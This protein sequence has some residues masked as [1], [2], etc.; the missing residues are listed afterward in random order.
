MLRRT[1]WEQGYGHY[2][3][4]RVMLYTQKLEDVLPRL[5]A[6]IPRRRK[7]IF[8]LD[9]FGYSQVPFR[10]LDSIFDT[11][12]KPEVILTFAFD[13]LAR[14]MQDYERLERQLQNLG[15]GG[16]TREE[17]DAAIGFQG[18]LQGLIQRLLTRAFLTKAKYYTPFFIISRESHVAYWLI[19]LSMHARARD[20]MTALHWEQGNKFANY[21]GSGH[22]MLGFD[23][24]QPPPNSQGSMFDEGARSRTEWKLQNDLPRLLRGYEGSVSFKQFFADHANS[25][26]ADS[27]IIRQVLIGLAEGRQVEIFTEDGGP[28]RVMTSLGP[29]DR[30]LFPEQPTFHFLSG[31][32]PVHAQAINSNPQAKTPSIMQPSRSKADPGPLLLPKQKTDYK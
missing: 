30:L 5:I 25:S 9:Q 4:D 7:A 16:L 23:P 15:V 28:K 32:L 6:G 17:F 2:I 31:P 1:L 24:Y 21:A 13:Q 10:L 22:N 14:W 18:G 20:V 29:N 3:G 12:N 27:E 8:L 26:P 19:H 11:L